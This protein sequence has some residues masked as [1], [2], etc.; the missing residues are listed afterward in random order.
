MYR[1][2]HLDYSPSDSLTALRSNYADNEHDVLSVSVHVKEQAA[3]RQCDIL[4]PMCARLQPIER[5][6]AFQYK[7]VWVLIAVG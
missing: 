2:A 4:L 7:R 6:F 1:I 3:G 5:P